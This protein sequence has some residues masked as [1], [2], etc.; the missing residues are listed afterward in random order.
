M[1]A[2]GV[3]GGSASEMARRKRAKAEKLLQSADAWDNGA[4]G[5]RAVSEILTWLAVDFHVLDDVDIPGSKA[6]GDHL[7]IGPTGVFLVDAKKWAGTLKA[8]KGTL[9]NGKF[10]IDRKLTTLTFEAERLAL[11]LG[12]RVIPV[13][14]FIDTGLPQPVQLCGNVIVCAGRSVLEVI[15]TPS[16]TLDSATIAATVGAARRFVR[17]NSLAAP[18]TEAAVFAAPALFATPGVSTSPLD[19]VTQ[20][21]MTIRRPLDVRP[22]RRRK[23]FTRMTVRPLLLRGLVVV[24]L[25]AATVAALPFVAKQFGHDDKRAA[26]TPGPSTASTTISS[27]PAT[28]AGPLTD[29]SAG[30]VTTDVVQFAPPGITFSCPTPGAGWTAT[31]IAT[32]F[33]ADPDGY[34]MW[35]EDMSASWVSWGVF[36]S[37]IS[38]PAALGGLAPGQTLHTRINRGLSLDPTLATD[39]TEFTTP[40]TPC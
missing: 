9:W 1:T 2:E 24:A 6:N 5:E 27:M 39:G 21:A 10:S 17:G 32:E 31:P 23:A 11:A 4:Q 28:G 15:T 14:C 37:G 22:G 36:K 29:P 7:V 26:A 40:T 18:V 16:S 34:N 3:A 13:M 35:Y 30:Q 20:P 25:A 8:G 38:A 33:R 12:R 19:T